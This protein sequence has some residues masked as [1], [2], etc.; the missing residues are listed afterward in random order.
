MSKI[1][2]FA[3]LIVTKL[4]IIVSYVRNDGDFSLLAVGIYHF[5]VLYT[6]SKSEMAFKALI[7][8]ITFF[9]ADIIQDVI[10]TALAA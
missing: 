8:F 1:S 4:K 7:E 6:I 2:L 9:G 10:L 5:L 3:C